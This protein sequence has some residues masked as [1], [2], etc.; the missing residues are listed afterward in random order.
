[1][2]EHLD[3]DPGH[4]HSIAAWTA[5]IIML[6][7]FTGGTFAFWFAVPWLVWAFVGVI[8]VGGLLGLVLTKL[9]YGAG[10]HRASQ[11]A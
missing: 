9:G 5:V 8:V 7:G 10:G 1:M 11:G 3:G 4:G 6:V 2:T